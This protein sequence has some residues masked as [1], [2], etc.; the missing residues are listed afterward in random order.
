MRFDADQLRAR[1]LLALE[2]AVQECRYRQPR[3]TLALRFSLAYLWSSAR[4]GRAPFDKFWQAL[5]GPKTPWSFGVADG[6]LLAIYVAMGIERDDKAGMALWK[7]L[8]AEE[9]GPSG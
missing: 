1:A 4:C 2:E 6:A 7:R 5:G 9:R 3:R 8:D